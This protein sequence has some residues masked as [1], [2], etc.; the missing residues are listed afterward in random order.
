ME[1]HIDETR[2]E[3][4]ERFIPKFEA[5]KKIDPKYVDALKW[6]L[7]YLKLKEQMSHYL[8]CNRCGDYFD[9]RNLGRVVIHE[10]C[11]RP[12]PFKQGKYEK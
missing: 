6:E 2:I 11:K 8:M 12:I 4:L 3:K 1:K 7:K 10:T 9:M 5:N